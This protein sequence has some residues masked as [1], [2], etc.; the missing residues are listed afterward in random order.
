VALLVFILIVLISFNFS[1]IFW[2]NS[3]TFGFLVNN[4]ASISHKV[5]NLLSFLDPAQ[6]ISTP[7]Y[8]YSPNPLRSESITNIF[9]TSL[10]SLLMSLANT[11]SP[12][13]TQWY[14]KSLYFIL[15]A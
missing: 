11:P 7:F 4:S 2:Q 5:S 9:S 10:P 3:L 8:V 1:Y 6:Y 14:L 12:P 13:L 15:C